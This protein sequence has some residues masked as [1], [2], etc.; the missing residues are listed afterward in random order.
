[1]SSIA[2]TPWAEQQRVFELPLEGDCDLDMRCA[3]SYTV[4]G[5][6]AG[7]ALEFNGQQVLESLVNF[8]EPLE[9]TEYL[10]PIHSIEV[11]VVASRE[12]P[13][14]QIWQRLVSSYMARHPDRPGEEWRDDIK[15]DVNNQ[16]QGVN[17]VMNGPRQFDEAR[18][19]P[20]PGTEYSFPARIL[21]W[22]DDTP[23]SRAIADLYLGAKYK[24]ENGPRSWPDRTGGTFVNNATYLLGELLV[25][26]RALHYEETEEVLA[27]LRNKW[28]IG[29]GP[30]VTDGMTL[31]F[32]A[33]D[34]Y[35]LTFDF[36]QGVDR[37][38]DK[39]RNMWDRETA[40]N[41]HAGQADERPLYRRTALGDRAPGLSFDGVNDW[42]DVGTVSPGR[43]SGF[44]VFMMMARPWQSENIYNHQR[45]LSS[46]DGVTSDDNKKPSW[47]LHGQFLDETTGS[48]RIQGPTVLVKSGPSGYAINNVKI[49]M[50]FNLYRRAS[51][52]CSE[53]LVYDREL[54][55]AEELVVIDY[56]IAK[57][58]FDTVFM[59]ANRNEGQNAGQ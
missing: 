3:P 14:Q 22:R 49:A 17:W 54:S 42:L 58:R 52:V 7:G 53:I 55:D 33:A 5:I 4:G 18:P 9:E 45:L 48:D 43:L 39:A 11:F 32:D 50:Q 24:F 29:L 12:T 31:W 35:T 56:L 57:W 38:L 13:G 8:T 27:Y 19:N 34:E 36:R 1:V 37:W 20:P 23:A 47:Y 15:Y 41:A 28:R 30:T 26:N 16:P 6:N 10:P 46:W 25:F 2:S 44:H 59:V 40:H 51:M 21:R